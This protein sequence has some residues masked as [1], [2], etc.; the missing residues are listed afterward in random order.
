MRL[1]DYALCIL[2]ASVVIKLHGIYS[3]WRL[4]IKTGGTDSPCR[5]GWT[6]VFGLQSLYRTIS[7][8][9]TLNNYEHYRDIFKTYGHTIHVIVFG[10][11]IFLT[12]HSENVKAMLATQFE[13]Y[14]KGPKFIAV[15]SQFLGNGIFNADGRTWKH[16]RA[17][18]RPQFARNRIAD[19]NIMHR[20]SQN[21]NSRIVSGEITNF[22]ELAYKMTLDAA[23]DYLFG[24]S[25]NSLQGGTADDGFAEAFAKIQQLQLK[26]MHYGPLWKL[27]SFGSH[28]NCL[29]KFVDRY[30]QETL[31]RN[32]EE[33][34]DEDLDEKASFLDVLAQDTRDPVVLRDHLVSLL[35]AGRDS[36]AATLCWVLKH[37]SHNPAAYAKLRTEVLAV[38]GEDGRAT[39]TQLKNM[40]YLN[41]CLDETLR[42]YP[43]LPMNQRAALVDTTLPRGGGKDGQSPVAVAKGD[44]IYYTP[45]V[46]HRTQDIPD[47]DKWIPERWEKWTPKPWTYIRES[48]EF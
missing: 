43:I 7:L 10:Q 35:L 26:R 37:L 24:D 44:I 29:D 13:D 27:V 20:H 19:L 9:W 47:V 6:D 38:V 5:S 30:V 45:L 28:I 22:N 32:V 3:Q 48:Q 23:T 39:Y 34:S 16:S 46:M 25:T 8:S 31:S 41:A 2:V 15:W 4:K 21:L 18:L 42:L 11:R 33:K 17:M 40:S 36:T 1:I 14:G 12:N